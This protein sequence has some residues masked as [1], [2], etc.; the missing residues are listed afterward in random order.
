MTQKQAQTIEQALE[1]AAKEGIRIIGT[2]TMKADGS[3]FWL[4]SSKDY[5]TTN[6]AYIVTCDGEHLHCNCRASGICKHRAI[7]HQTLKDE[8]Q[9]ETPASVV[10]QV[11]ATTEAQGLE[12]LLDRETPADEWEEMPDDDAERRAEAM[13][14][15]TQAEID[16]ETARKRETALPYDHAGEGFSIFAP[17][18]PGFSFEEAR[19]DPRP[20][21]WNQQRHCYEHVDQAE[22]A[23]RDAVV[24]AQKATMRT[25]V[26]ARQQEE[27]QQTQGPRPAPIH[28]AS[29]G[30]NHRDHRNTDRRLS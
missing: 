17:E 20:M 26:Q 4:V 12:E 30:D 14:R 1:R 23:A 27:W 9:A 22:I 10:E 3:H 29:K 6:R 16:R 24:A 15:E 18:R 21:R 7:V 25:G 19:H 2:G 13:R 8:R 11:I 28:I 5:A